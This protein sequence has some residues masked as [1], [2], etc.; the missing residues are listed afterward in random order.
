M[1]FALVEELKII[2]NFCFYFYCFCLREQRPK[3][4]ISLYAYNQKKL[5]V[6]QCKVQI[7]SV[8]EALS[9]LLKSQHLLK[10]RMIFI[11]E[12]EGVGRGPGQEERVF[13]KQ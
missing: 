11:A 8:N 2:K 4:E 6:Y 13:L 10:S 3:L 12:D 7:L 9:S 5:A 1:L